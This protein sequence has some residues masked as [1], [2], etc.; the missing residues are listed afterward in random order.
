MTPLIALKKL[1]REFQ[2][3]DDTITVLKDIDL[4]IE[5]G[6]MIA[7]V[8]AS[9]SGKST[10]MNIVG[11]LD[12]PTSGSYEIAGRET[13][14]LSPDELAE[15]R[16]EHFGFIFQR[17]H[18]LPE[19]TAVRNVEV[20]AIYAGVAGHE[21]Q[22][23][24]AALLGRLGM[25]DRLGHR[26]GQL[27]GGQQ[28]RVSIARA[29]IN[30]ADII[31]ADEPTGALDRH[32][33]EEVLAILERLNAEGKTVFI[34]THD[35]SIAARAR[36]IVEISDGE[37]VSDRPGRTARLAAATPRPIGEAPRSWQAIADRFKE[38]FV[39]AVL[40]MQAHRLRTFLTMLGIV[41]GIASVV[42]VVALGEG[43]R[44]QVLSNIRNLGT[45][46]LEIFPG[47]DFGDVR[48]AKV[49]TLVV[50]DAVALA[51]QPYVAGVTPTVSLTSTLRYG[52]IEASAMI[53]GVGAQYFDVKGTKLAD[54]RFFG[55]DGVREMAQEAVIDENTRKTLFGGLSASPVGEIILIGTVPCRVIGVTQKQQS[56]FGASQNL[57]VYLPYSTVQARF[58]GNLSLRSITLR[59][60]D[61]TATDV[62]EQAATSLLE[63]RHGARDF[64]VLN[65][66]DIRQTITQ[67]TE[68]MTLLIAAIAVISLLVGGIGV[69][70][71]MLVSVV[72]RTN[73]IGVRMAVG[74][75]RSDILQ[76]FMIEAILVCLVGGCLGI[77][78]ALAFGIGFTAFGSHFS[79]VYSTTSIVSA[80]VCS[81]LIGVVFGF[82][83][84][85]NAARL[86]PVV[87]LAR[88]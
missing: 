47:K 40:A 35:M 78:A 15:L 4:V 69:M 45:N 84:A 10:L 42:C 6:E 39:M 62:A 44:Q 72:E 87:A 88:E 5:A 83:P 41:I 67:T 52:A 24:A 80:V 43:S 48:S 64:F 12:R 76:Q 29:L 28:Q 2:S 60:N 54:G 55:A 81:T 3:G 74:A 70:N 33:G 53:N 20:P 23:R 7:I 14:Q 32:S 75:R 17:Y 9:G 1:R 26:P 31:L 46:T 38:A 13:S 22:G 27:S 79:L 61:D 66:D 11:C 8:G 71:I 85:R 58:L 30:G 37:I 73:E 82:L 18:L 56:G 65:T 21:R 51:R 86:D 68:T 19:L 77:A 50:A 49:K 57:S 34:V 59:V 16:R 25:A 36:R 63:H